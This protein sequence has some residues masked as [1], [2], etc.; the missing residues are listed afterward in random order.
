MSTQKD[1][2]ESKLYQL[3]ASSHR[4]NRIK[5]RAANGFRIQETITWYLWK[6][7]TLSQLVEWKCSVFFFGPLKKPPQF[8]D[9]AVQKIEQNLSENDDL[10][11]LGKDYEFGQNNAKKQKL[12]LKLKISYFLMNHNFVPVIRLKNSDIYYSAMF[13]II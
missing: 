8:L 2:Q 3:P 4:A 7:I 12:P 13:S 6:C 10:I 5:I 1:W 9:A 11:H